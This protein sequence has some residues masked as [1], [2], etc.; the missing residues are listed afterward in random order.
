MTAYVK[1]TAQT[2]RD[3]LYYIERL[4]PG[5]TRATDELRRA[6]RL[7][8]KRKPDTRKTAKQARRATKRLSRA[9]IRARVIARAS[10][11]C[12]CGCGRGF[13]LPWG[14][15]ELDHQFGRARSESFE[16]CWAIRAD[17]HYDKTKNQPSV[18]YWLLKFIAHCKKHG[19]R[20]AQAKAE[21][22]L[23]S[24]QLIEAAQKSV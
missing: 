22:R 12:E 3:A 9:A 8:P 21:A 7:K 1:I 2:A 10:G 24:L 17:C 4:L 23:E 20:Q 16:T 15:L 11:E 19:Y 13:G 6:L 5:G 18:A 14:M